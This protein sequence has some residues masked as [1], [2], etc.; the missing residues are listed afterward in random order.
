M[1]NLQEKQRLVHEIARQSKD[2]PNILRSFTRREL[3][4]IICAELGKER[5][6][7]GY[8][9]NQMIEHLLKII[10][11]NSKLHVI[12]NTLD[13]SPAKSCIGSKRKKGPPSQDL[14]Y[15]PPGT[16]KEE[17]V[18]ILLCR[19]VACKA[20]L[21]PEDSFCK[22]CSCCICHCYDDN[23]DPSL[24]LTCSSDLPNEE[25]CGMSCH[26]QCAL[27]NKMSGILK[28]SCGVKLDGS[29]SCVSCGKI[30]KLMR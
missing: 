1:L 16:G 5:K 19:N 15:A 2:A 13:H 24:W 27:S 26:L 29:F 20:T 11:R 18:K 22:R 23:K 14:H 6:Y 21:N 3:L 12:Q 9:K 8:T 25:S 28:S 30:N 10:S 17:K 7:T 4:E